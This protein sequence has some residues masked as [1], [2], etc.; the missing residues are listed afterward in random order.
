MATSDKSSK[1]KKRDSSENKNQDKD[2][3]P[4]NTNSWFWN[5]FLKNALVF[6]PS[7][8]SVLYVPKSFA[9]NNPLPN[10]DIVTIVIIEDL[11]PSEKIQT[12]L[13]GV[14]K[15][16][17][18]KLR[19]LNLKLDNFYQTH[20]DNLNV[21]RQENNPHISS[22]E[23]KQ[24]KKDKQIYEWWL[25]GPGN[26]SFSIEIQEQRR[27]KLIELS[28]TIEL[29][30][31]YFRLQSA[32]FDYKRISH[33]CLDE[34]KPNIKAYN[35][36]SDI[37]I[38]ANDERAEFINSLNNMQK[39]EL[40]LSYNLIGVVNEQAA[41]LNQFQQ[42]METLFEKQVK[43]RDRITEI[44]L[45]NISYVDDIGFIPSTSEQNIYLG[46]LHLLLDENTVMMNSIKTESDG[47][48]ESHIN[49][50]QNVIDLA[51]TFPT[52]VDEFLI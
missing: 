42:K 39:S 35:T 9:V 26:S 31:K 49:M 51:T 27:V 40:F 44:F 13:L 3:T 4:S 50:N 24:F 1:D 10:Q 15:K 11:S 6:I 14:D 52:S 20:L 38:S 23:R 2:I 43:D 41:C 28:A 17:R 45:E 34:L 5:Y 36:F 47:L 8:I 37:C 33:L 7:L 48:K 22:L 30:S 19:K 29:K 21:L 25:R 16:Y 12:K 18:K 32:I 46:K